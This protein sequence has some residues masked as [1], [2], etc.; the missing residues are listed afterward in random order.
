MK[1]IFRYASLLFAA[2]VLSSCGGTVDPDDPNN[3][4]EKEPEEL[5]GEFKI[6]TDKN[7]IQTF[8]DYATITVTIGETVL[9]EGVIFYNGEN[10]QINLSDSK[11]STTE[12][13]VYTIWASYGTLITD[14]ITITAVN[15]KIPD[16]P[17]DPNP[18]STDFKA[19]VLAIEFTTTGCTYCPYM[20]TLLK[21]A[22]SHPALQGELITTACHPGIINQKD[23]AY[24]HT[25]FDEFV[26]C[27]S[28][29][30]M[31]FDMYEGYS[32]PPL[33]PDVEGFVNMLNQFYNYKK[34]KASGIAVNSSIANDQLVAKVTVKAAE[35]IEYRVGAFLLEDGIEAKQSGPAEEWMN[36]HN[37]VIRYIDSKYVNKAGKVQYYGHS[38]GMVEKGKTADYIFVWNLKDI[39]TEGAKNGEVY[40][41]YYW[42]P[43]VEENL[44]LA[45]FVTAIGKDEKGNELYYV[46]NVIDCPV[47]GKTQFE[48]S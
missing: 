19:R 44:H 28:Y 34:D 22:V 48:Y 41:K 35:S 13:G 12:P 2:A 40:G 21:D 17:A 36:T 18:S 1:N 11:F 30:F 20:K 26:G 25:D 14:E 33:T 7:L 39:W 38:L 4:V 16:T 47:N 10:R 31:H 32:L 24:I 5:T 29:P 42:D 23:P 8:D 45:V 6:T 43:F 3:K 37:N 27:S 15:A 46:N 9:K